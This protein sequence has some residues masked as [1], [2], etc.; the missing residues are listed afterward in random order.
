[1]P[2]SAIADKSKVVFF[3]SD[4]RLY[5]ASELF[6]RPGYLFTPR[7]LGHF[8]YIRTWQ[9]FWNNTWDFNF[10]MV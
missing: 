1:M 3:S 6:W 7:K 4:P 8:T 10:G 2:E 5:V 9:K